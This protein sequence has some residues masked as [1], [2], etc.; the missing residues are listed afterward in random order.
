M[1][2]IILVVWK[3]RDWAKQIIS[4]DWLQNPEHSH[5]INQIEKAKG[6]LFDE[7]QVCHPGE[8]EINLVDPEAK[9][10]RIWMQYEPQDQLVLDFLS[11]L[12]DYYKKEDSQLFVFLHR[13]DGFNNKAVNFLLD[14]HP[15]NRYFLFGGGRDYIYYKT[16]NEGLL[17]DDSIFYSQIPNRKQPAIHVADDDRKLVFQPHFDKVWNHY[18]HEFYSKI[19]EL[20]EDILRHFFQLFPDGFDQP[21]SNYL[22]HL[23]KNEPLLWRVKSFMDDACDCFSEKEIMKLEQY[24]K[25]NHKSFIFDDCRANLA[26]VSKIDKEYDDVVKLLNELLFEKPEKIEGTLRHNLKELNQ[27]FKELLETIK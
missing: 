27:E 22:P 8:K 1:K 17:G 4:E 10:V 13:R 11:N 2:R 15:D 5:W 9:V 20:R 18:E 14:N 7:Y 23:K 26:K 12:V 3:W 21:F 19:Y 6:E 25:D 16:Q 24:G